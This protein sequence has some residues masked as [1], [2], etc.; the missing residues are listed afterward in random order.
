MNPGGHGASPEVPPPSSTPPP[1]AREPVPAAEAS[2]SASFAKA[3]AVMG[4]GAAVTVGLG[5]YGNVHSPTGVAV[6]VA[7]FSAPRTAKVWLTTAVFA[8]A[9]LQLASAWAMYR[10]SRR[11]KWIGP[12]HR[13]SG[14][15]AFLLAVPVAV[16]CLYAL[17]FQAYDTRVLAHSF[18]GTFFFGVF[19]V[20]MLALSQEGLPDRLL[21][22]LGGTV[23][24]ALTGLWLTSSL[25]FFTTV[26]VLYY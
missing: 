7:G 20:K 19:T 11:P 6:N 2:A 10:M 26:G 22:W 25:W 4:A 8:F 13:W 1:T 5:V 16:H 23:F 15:A 18:L 21:P 24:T 17:G 3:L 9:L 14:R 12:L